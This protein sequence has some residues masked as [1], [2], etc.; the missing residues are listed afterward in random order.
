MQLDIRALVLLYASSLKKGFDCHKYQIYL[1]RLYHN[2][3]Y[4]KHESMK[5][6]ITHYLL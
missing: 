3:Y 6:Y 4:Y 5:Y 2:N 1:S